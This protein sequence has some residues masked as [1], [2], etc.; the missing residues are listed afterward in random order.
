MQT[1][2]IAI[3]DDEIDLVNLFREAL[4]IDGFK[5]CTFT[6]P[7]EALKRL[8]TNLEDYALVIS[9]FKMPVM[10]GNI[11]CNK[12]IDINPKLKVILISAYQDVECDISKF[13]FLNK[14]IQISQLLKIVKE[15][16]RE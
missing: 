13:I 1:K 7:N 15:T 5:V 3:I 11:L 6:D 4:E 10:N 14:P 8:Q 16:L 2:S 12:L 9:D